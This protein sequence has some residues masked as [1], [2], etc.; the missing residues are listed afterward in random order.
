[1]VDSSYTHWFSDASTR[2]EVEDEK[3]VHKLGNIYNSTNT[4]ASFADTGIQYDYRIYPYVGIRD[5]RSS[6]IQVRTNY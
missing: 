3:Q 6:A 2:K 5:C 1:M 4:I